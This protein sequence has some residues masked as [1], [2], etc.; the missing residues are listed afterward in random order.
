[1]PYFLRIAGEITV[2]LCL[3]KAGH[4]FA[5]SGKKPALKHN[6]ICINQIDSIKFKKYTNTYIGN[7]KNGKN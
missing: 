2:A 7:L 3:R 1:M 4:C 5:I 6:E